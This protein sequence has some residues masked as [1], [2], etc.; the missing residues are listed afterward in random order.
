M[1]WAGA[2]DSPFQT[3]TVRNCAR[4]PARTTVASTTTGLRATSSRTL[5][6]AQRASALEWKAI[7]PVADASTTIRAR[8]VRFQLSK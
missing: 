3:A 7:A 1:K 6:L 4:L 8:L 2:S 5:I